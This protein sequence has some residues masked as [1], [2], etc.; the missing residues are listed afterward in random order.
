MTSAKD[1][2]Q[3]G[4]FVAAAVMLLAIIEGALAATAQT[5]PS[6][7]SPELAG[8]RVE[9]IRVIGRARPLS[10]ATLSEVLRQVRTREGEPFDPAVAEADYQRIY[11]LRRFSNVEARVEP[12]ATGV[13]VVFEVAEQDQI[14]EIRI[15]GND[16][17]DTASIQAVIDL[18]VGEAIDPF[19]LGLARDAIVRLY[20]NKNQPHAHV[21][22]D[23]DELKKGIVVFK[24][25]EGPK[26]R[27]RRI[28]ILGNRSF[29]DSRIKEQIKS[30]SWFPLF[31]AGTFD[32]DIIEQDVA[33][34]RQF[35]E[36]H[37]FFD[38]RVGRKIVVS[39]TQKE[40]M[41]SFVIEEG[42]RYIVEKVRFNIQPAPDSPPSGVTEAELRKDL[43]LVEGRHY[44]ADLVKRDIRQIVKVYSPRGY[45]YVPQDPNP[46][47]DYMRIREERFF[48]REAGRVEVVYN[49]QE[50]KAF[51]LGQIIV[52]KN[53]KTQ[54]KVILREMRVQPGQL[55]NSAEIA[56]ATDRIR[57]TGLFQN[58]TITPIVPP[59]ATGEEG[60]PPVRAL[61]VE[62][63]EAQTARFLI[64]A[65][66]TSNV[67]LLGNITYEQ[68]N[69]DITNWPSTPSELF[70]G[71]TFSGAGQTFRLQIEP[72][73]ELTRARVDF[74]EPWLFDRPFSFGASAYLSQR[75]RRDWYEN[76]IGGRLSLGHRFT[77]EWSARV[78]LRGEDVEIADID[79]KE[80][81]AVEV[82]EYEGHSTLTSTG[83][84]I[85]HDTT[86]SP[87]LPS[88][89]TITTFAWEH[90]G[91][92]G[93]DFQFDKFTVGFNFYQTI[94]EDLLERKTILA[95]RTDAGYIT[96]SAPFFERFYG[97]GIGSLRGFR[98][99]GVS[100]RSG[101]EDDPVGGD[102]M[103]T[104]SVEL[105]FP[106]AGD[107]LR[108]VV[109]V[110]AGTVERDME[111]GTIRTSVGFGIRLTLPVFGQLPIALDFGFPI[112]KDD[113]DETRIFS[114]ALGLTQ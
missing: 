62:V 7:I 61:L 100:P 48:R 11:A 8:R 40:V 1:L 112:T 73:T 64:G 17:V 72:G 21:E 92:F 77:N 57:A 69:F 114:F 52:A 30:K 39:P 104:A 43:K 27:I 106:L 91:T 54:D 26:V 75:L 5:R 71:R 28:Q 94:Y 80:M 4:R 79:D 82:L 37:G 84:E 102:F 74:V 36:N 107:M 41:V 38:V 90:Y 59:D 78:F 70:S 88:K 98:Y 2:N 24:V 49:I 87:L 81:R 6:A 12:T 56:S 46:D 97:G 101:I 60:Q 50:G 67:G 63:Q 31:V 25:V 10:S 23:D 93:G 9:E 89:G 35:Y 47:K 42:R 105:N 95:V 68:R 110:D 19:R 55:Y 34:I 85:R 29:T 66:I 16:D 76:R 15:V 111:I 86:D 83:L 3:I 109:F 108:G 99:R 33:A 53:A 32:P 44:D 20:R 22:V 113:L 96:G 13:I 103:L 58:V 18:K 14:K 65:G 45:I 51:R